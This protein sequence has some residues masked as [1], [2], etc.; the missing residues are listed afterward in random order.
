MTLKSNANF[1]GQGHVLN[2]ELL[3]IFIIVDFFSKN[4]INLG[5]RV[6]FLMSRKTT[7]NIFTK[8]S[9][10]YSYL[11]NYIKKIFFD[12]NSSDFFKKK[13]C[14]VFYEVFIFFINFNDFLFN[15][16]RFFLIFQKKKL[17]Y[18]FY[19]FNFFFKYL[20]TK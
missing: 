1:W 15:F 5:Q 3:Y 6:K 9:P 4:N 10:F 8:L 20:R 14:W 17:K 16:L 2:I 13:T 19:F 11:K 18:N 12:V 7:T